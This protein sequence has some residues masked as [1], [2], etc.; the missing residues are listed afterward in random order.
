MF[1]SIKEIMEEIDKNYQEKLENYILVYKI[2][3][4]KN[5]HLQNE[6]QLNK[7]EDSTNN[8]VHKYNIDAQFKIIFDNIE[9]TKKV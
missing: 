2:Q 4:L 7:L 8:F 3:R 9:K 1:K 6:I 5:N